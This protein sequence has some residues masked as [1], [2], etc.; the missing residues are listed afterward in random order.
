MN[1]NMNNN[2]D[3]NNMDAFDPTDN[4]FTNFDLTNNDFENYSSTSPDLT[5]FP[6]LQGQNSDPSFAEASSSNNPNIPPAY[7]PPEPT[8]KPRLSCTGC[9]KTFDNQESLT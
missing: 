7:V 4:N 3:I 8:S 9:D 6:E 1:N 5:Y 2:H